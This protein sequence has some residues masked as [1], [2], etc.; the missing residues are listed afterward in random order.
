MI[1]L[2]R[3]SATIGSLVLLGILL[4][5]VLLI[6]NLL[7]RGVRLD[8]TENRLYTLSDGT[9]KILRNLDEPVNLYFFFS[10]RVSADMPQLQGLRAYATRVRELLE[11]MVAK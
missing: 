1:N 9:V 11:E 6:S 10:D 7:L 5:A 4:L 3:R 8:L 2:S